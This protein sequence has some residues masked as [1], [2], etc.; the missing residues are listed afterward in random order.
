MR[1]RVAG[2]L[3]DILLAGERI[4]QFV[5]GA[6]LETYTANPLVRSAV[7]RQFEIIGE[8][9]VRLRRHA[10][11][12][13]AQIPE[14]RRIVG[15]RNV[16]AHGYDVV[17]DTVVWQAVHEHLPQLLDVVRS[18]LENDATTAESPE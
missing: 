9:L 5:A 17:D 1:R 3:Y 10:P 6:S 12:I 14:A 11:E 18:L 4:Q 2:L 16:L 8:A 15:F 13:F 7:E